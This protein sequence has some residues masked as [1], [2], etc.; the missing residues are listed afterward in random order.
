MQRDAEDRLES[1]SYTRDTALSLESP[2][3]WRKRAE[4]SCEEERK[5]FEACPV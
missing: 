1:L 5:N 4:G 2:D 3:E